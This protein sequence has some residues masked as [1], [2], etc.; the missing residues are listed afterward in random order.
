MSK[1]INIKK[2]IPIDKIEK[3]DFSGKVYALKIKNDPSYC[4]SDG[5]LSSNCDLP[6]IDIDFEHK[7][8]DQVRQYL[9]KKYGENNVAGISTFLEMKGKATV[10]DVSRVFDIPLKEA[11]AFAKA[12]E[13]GDEKSSIN[14]MLRTTREG[15]I[16]KSKYP[17]QAKYS[18]KLEG[19]I[20][21]TG[22]HAAAV[23]ISP[24]NLKD[25]GIANLCRRGKD[26]TIVINW[27][28]EDAEYMGLVKLDILGLN[29]L[30]ILSE[31]NRLIE[32]NYGKK[33]KFHKIKP[34]NPFVF[35]IL[36][37][38]KTVGIFQLSTPLSTDICKRTKIDTFEDIA[39]VL[40]IARPGALHSGMTEDFINRKH[41]KKWKT[42]NSLY[43]KI[44]EKTYGVLIYQEQVMEVFHKVAGLP[45]S[46]ADNIRKIIGKKRDASEFEQYKE[47]FLKGCLEKRTFNKEEVEWFWGMLL[48]CSSYLFNRSHAIEYAMLAY[49]TAWTKYFYPTEFICASLTCGEETK[50]EEFI[51][52]AYRMGLK[53]I[54]PKIGISDAIKWKA[55][56][57][58]LYCPFIEIK[59]VG[60]STAQKCIEKT[61]PNK[62][63]FFELFAQKEIESKTKI[64]KILNEIKAF[65][66][67]AIPKNINQ[68]FAFNLK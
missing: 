26:R 49:W 8:R 63:G 28:M 67:K 41:G 59:G 13:Y 29:T 33:I 68:Y 7:K 6:D 38:G 56:N 22:Q 27:D 43:E 51:E 15:K 2:I 25:N 60:L 42:K 52:E 54:P 19:T 50:K 17:L 20:K 30:S 46:V 1:Q 53:I 61:L 12:I 18:S 16:F 10:R 9:I 34:V 31:T 4:L 57:N 11:D 55:K 14:E 32:E 64:D 37:K 35:K 39:S 36:T 23:I 65:D 5:I 21:S 45:Y 58:T 47:Q 40:A 48:E 24:R 3:V 62:I 66:R 44:T